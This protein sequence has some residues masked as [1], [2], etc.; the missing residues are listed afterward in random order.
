MNTE[1]FIACLRTC[2]GEN[3]VISDRSQVLPYFEDWWGRCKG[4]ALCVV[5]PRS[6]AEV[7]QVVA[8]C[9]RHAVPIYVQGGNTSVCAGSVPPHASMGIVLNMSLMSRVIDVSVEDGAMTVEAG[10]VLATVQEAAAA[11]GMLFPLS[12]G[13]E[14]SCQIGGNIATNAG[15]TAVL[16]YGNM[17]DL[18]LGLEVV[19]PDGRVWNGLRTLRKDNTGY[20]LRALFIGSEGTLGVVTA[21]TLRL[22]PHQP[23]MITAFMSHP[24]L[25][26]TLA[27]AQMLRAQFGGTLTALEL[28][29]RSELQLVLKHV[30]HVSCPLDGEAPWFLLVDIACGADRDALL[31]EFEA[32]LATGIEDGLIE[33]VVIP[34]NMA[35]REALWAIRHSVTEAN[36]TE[37]MGF[38]HDVAVPLRALHAFI[39]ETGQ[40]VRTTFPQ[41]QIVIV[42]HLGDGNLHYNVMF[43]KSVWAGIAD[44]A[45]MKKRVN[46]L[47]YDQAM[48]FKGSFSA[49]HGIGA[50]HVPEMA[51]YKDDLELQM[52]EA[53]KAAFD[54]TNIMNPGRV[55]PRVMRETSGS[56]A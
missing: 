13:A 36:K 8:L 7:S 45:G 49:E 34:A 27:V 14:G 54:P 22:F 46:R 12:L 3:G 55:L 2:V 53:V 21:A 24:T 39:E 25:E 47:V 18:V 48:R 4:D 29:S 38:S 17:R 33:D 26:A 43:E 20:D 19:L 30:P 1:Q 41:A 10:C 52:M 37:G 42:G 31:A 23:E 32:R 51:A 9:H 35:Q 28:I 6:T 44:Q 11:A 15:G 16:R 40:A 5:R 50:L 56:A